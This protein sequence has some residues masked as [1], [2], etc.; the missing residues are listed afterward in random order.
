ML[1]GHSIGC[2]AYQPGSAVDWKKWKSVRQRQMVTLHMNACTVE[3]I[4][5]PLAVNG[6]KAGELDEL[7]NKMRLVEIS[8]FH[9]ELRPV[10]FCCA[11]R[12]CDRMLES[13][14]AAEEL[15]CQANFGGKHLDKSPL[16]QIHSSCDIANLRPAVRV[17]S[18]SLWSFSHAA[19]HS[20]S[21]RSELAHCSLRRRL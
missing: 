2:H 17:R 6:T 21:A 9:G 1:R 8:A 12:R 20:R 18:V 11:S 14:H 13:L 16:A 5:P 3:L 19:L 7:V 15:R 10:D 4:L